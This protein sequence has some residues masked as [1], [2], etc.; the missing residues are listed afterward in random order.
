MIPLGRTF[1]G[2]LFD[3]AIIGGGLSI[4]A[5]PILMLYAETVDALTLSVVLLAANSA[6]FAASTVRLYT[7]PGAVA[8]WP[9]VAAGLP[10]ATLAVL[11][12][13][14][15]LG[16]WLGSHLYSLAMTWSP[17]HY[18]AQAYG[19]S[20]LYCRRS[21]YPVSGVGQNWLYAACMIPF[22]HAFV[23]SSGAGVE[24]FVPTAVLD[25]PLVAPLRAAV[26]LG[27]AFATFVGPV[28]LFWRLQRD[29]GAP[30]PGIVALLIGSNGLWWAVFPYAGAFAWA[31]V[32]HGLQYLAIVLVFH[33]KEQVAAPGNSRSPLVLSLRFYA[34]SLAL[35]YALFHALP[36]AYTAVGFAHSESILLVVAMINIHHFIV[37]RYIWRVKRDPGNAA[38]AES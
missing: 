26:V 36:E 6:H 16:D 5:I 9:F 23:G 22:L 19:L 24:W 7:K 3:A 14:M 4:V 37:D 8:D 10:L 25:D 29:A 12:L 35:A 27:L 31:T 15:V 34:I 2:P 17:F 30:P 18:A 11:S 21:G 1:V 28:L 33:V 20:M 13:C 38:V 32:F